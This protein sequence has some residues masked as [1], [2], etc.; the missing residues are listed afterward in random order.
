M[1]A[2][3]LIKSGSG[4]FLSVA[5]SALVGVVS[6]PVVI[7]V[8]G[9]AAWS[10]LAVAQA[11]GAIAATVVAFGWP[12]IGPAAVA[13]APDTERGRIFLISLISRAVIL[14]P[15]AGVA[16]V[17]VLLSV[18]WSTTTAAAIIA[19]LTPVIGGLTASW[20]FVGESRPSKLNSLDVLPRAAGTL[21]G[22]AL[23]LAT[24]SLV[25][26]VLGQL[27]GQLGALAL[28]WLSIR[29]RYPRGGHISVRDITGTVAA[30]GAGF[31]NAILTSLYQNSPLV[32]VTNFAG[33]GVETYAM[34]DRLFR[35][36]ALA[37]APVTQVAQG[38][39]PSAGTHDE[40]LARIRRTIIV[41]AGLGVATL[42]GFGFLAPV[43]GT[44]LSHGAI[45]VSYGVSFCLGG[46]LGMALMS[47][48]VGRACLVP[49]KKTATLALA[50]TVAAIVGLSGMV[51]GGIAFGIAGV[52]SAYLLAEI[53]AF[54]ITIW[55]A[56]GALRRIDKRGHTEGK[57]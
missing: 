45:E 7:Q 31:S 1:R 25:L 23:I 19:G 34:A 2:P 3:R 32:V 17:V 18:G 15:A 56:A 43:L 50:A 9:A 57:S 6:V 21:I 54:S 16:T 41:G 55:P 14:I 8:A 47:S 46:A 20:F 51:A 52:A 35:I 40:L 11:A 48:L 37:L 33:A 28:S 4:Y 26:F 38:Y 12:V 5:I 30:G 42:I 29:R 53:L 39:V 13:A 22:I 10:T 24:S 49:L 36:A 27:A 44:L